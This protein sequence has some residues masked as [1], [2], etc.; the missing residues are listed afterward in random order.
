MKPLEKILIED[1]PAVDGLIFR[2]FN[3][4][5]DYPLML[6]QYDKNKKKFVGIV[7]APKLDE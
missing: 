3:G 7:I 5:E 6:G 4:E 1:A 2:K